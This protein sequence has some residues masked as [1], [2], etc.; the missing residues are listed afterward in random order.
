MARTFDTGVPKDAAAR[1][2][3]AIPAC[4]RLKRAGTNVITEV[5]DDKLVYRIN[6]LVSA[7]NLEAT[8]AGGD[9]GGPAL[10]NVNGRWYVAGVIGGSWGP[11]PVNW[12]AIDGNRHYLY[13]VSTF[14]RWIE[15]VTG[16]NFGVVRRDRIVA[17][18]ALGVI[19]V[20][21]CMRL[22]KRLKS[23]P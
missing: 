16:E 12:P 21:V 13:R 2:I 9:S 5:L 7:T 15:D 4:E 22:A 3:A 17:E 10:I 19:L 8:F 18:V 23:S 20:L 6:S 14:A 11:A 1:N